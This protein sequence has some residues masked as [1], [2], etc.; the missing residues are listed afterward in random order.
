MLNN[1]GRYWLEPGSAALLP[2]SALL[3][4]E[5]PPLYKLVDSHQKLRVCVAGA[6][7]NVC[8]SNVEHQL[9]KSDTP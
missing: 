7:S 8:G 1:V 4:A 5:T 6:L 3:A 2:T 9:A